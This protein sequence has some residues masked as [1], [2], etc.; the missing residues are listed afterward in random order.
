MRAERW[1]WRRGRWLVP[2]AGGRFAPWV[3]ARRADGQA[4]FA[5]GKWV[6]ARGVELAA[7][8]PVVLADAV[9]TAV[10]DEFGADEEVGRDSLE[11]NPG[12]PDGGAP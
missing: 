1:R 8:R 11:E 5:P 4:L 3:V 2:P 10:M 7:P 12:A 6:D 9:R